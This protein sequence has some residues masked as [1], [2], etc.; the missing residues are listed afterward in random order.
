M[1][2]KCSCKKCDWYQLW[3]QGDQYRNN[4]TERPA[5]RNTMRTMMSLCMTEDQYV[6]K[7]MEWLQWGRKKLIEIVQ[8]RAGRPRGTENG[9]LPTPT[10]V[11]WRYH[12]PTLSLLCLHVSCWLVWGQDEASVGMS[13]ESCLMFQNPHLCI[14]RLLLN[15]TVNS[16]MWAL[17]WG[18]I[19]IKFGTQGLA[20]Q[21]WV[22]FL[23]NQISM[24]NDLDLF[25]F[26]TYIVGLS[27]RGIERSCM[28]GYSVWVIFVVSILC[29]KGPADLLVKTSWRVST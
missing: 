23:L 2:L 4:E 20:S 25:F 8:V 17:T 29:P 18:N 3:G 12:P 6:Q 14:F 26:T 22:S 16:K 7:M 9:H 28:S 21:W 13:E 15:H 19:S 5:G 10:W 27:I 24:L 11:I 1:P